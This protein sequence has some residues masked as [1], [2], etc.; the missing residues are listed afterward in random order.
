MSH[1]S[2]T[3][4]GVKCPKL[5]RR[6][7][8]WNPKHGTW[9]AK[10]ELPSGP[11]GKRVDLKAGGF[12]SED[13]LRDWFRDAE[14][15]LSIPD[16]GPR[17][18]E[19]RLEILALIKETRKRSEDLPDYDD[20]RLRHKQGAALKTGLLG[21]YLDTWLEGKKSIRRNTVRGYESHI[22]VHLKPHLGHIELDKLR[23]ADI[24]AM[25]TAI[26]TRNEQILAGKAKGR[27]TSP[28]TQKLILATLS[29]ALGDAYPLLTFNPASPKY[30]EM[31]P[32]KR[33]KPLLWNAARE[34]S[35]RAAYEKRIA[36]ERAARPGRNVD[37]FKIWRDPKM[38]PSKVMVWTPTQTGEFLDRATG[39][40]LYPLF[41]LVTHTGMRRGE[42][43]GA[44]VDSLDLDAGE[45]LVSA[46]LVQLGWE[47]EDGDPKTEASDALIAL[48]AET[49]KVLRAHLKR[50]NEERLAWGETWV[51]SGK[52][53]CWENG[54][55]YHP[56]Y[57]TDQFERLAFE[58]SLPPITLHG[59]R[60]GAAT[61]LLA[62]GV[63]RKVVSARLRHSSVQ[64]TQDLYTQVLG[65]LAREAAEKTAAMIPRKVAVGEVLPTGRAPK[66]PPRL[67]SVPDSGDK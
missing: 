25:F 52:L 6:D 30:V 66:G 60:H 17:G 11:D 34:K 2:L 38:R 53:F 35:W 59:L 44:E 5:R 7:G 37:A 36:D 23:P 55:P 41:Q 20:V 4:R 22:R 8:T 62:A 54:Q 50:R 49:V 14:L 19:A 15:L 43:C 48:D 51:E 39:H 64:T 13:E 9:Y 47:V 21:E 31:T 12:T 57:V 24:S 16:R 40:R 29:N 46:N 32:V 33:Q 1:S 27:I 26:N 3:E 56:A 28:A 10:Q 67:R 63:D 18:H 65:E 42:G 61:M 58:A 45:L